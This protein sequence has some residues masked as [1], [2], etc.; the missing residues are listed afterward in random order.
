[1]F[2]KENTYIKVMNK[3][4][5]SAVNDDIQEVIVSKSSLNKVSQ[6]LT[7]QQIRIVINP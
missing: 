6:V 4:C 1:M 3:T 5:P 7:C 2:D